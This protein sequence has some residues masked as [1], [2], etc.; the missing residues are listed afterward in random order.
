M[1]IN[2]TSIINLSDFNS[3]LLAKVHFNGPKSGQPILWI[4][5]KIID[6]KYR[7]E[8]IAFPKADGAQGDT[9]A[10]VDP[11]EIFVH[12]DRVRAEAEISFAGPRVKELKSENLATESS[13]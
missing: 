11:K 5:G 10:L 9:I 13:V 12:K 3:G 1:L 7:F 8:G 6:N 4:I 2:D